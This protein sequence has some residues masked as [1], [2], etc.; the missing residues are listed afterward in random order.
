MFILANFIFTSF[1]NIENILIKVKGEYM[2]INR[3]DSTSFGAIHIQTSKMNNWQKLVSE[4]MYHTIKYSDKY[5]EM[6]KGSVDVDIYM[7]PVNK[8]D[9]ELRLVDTLSENFIKSRRGNIYKFIADG[10]YEYEHVAN[11]VLKAYEM[12]LNGTIKRPKENVSDFVNGNTD[13]CRIYP[14][15]HDDVDIKEIPRFI[16]DGMTKAEA[17]QQAYD[18]HKWTI[19]DYNS[20]DTEF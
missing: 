4:K 8:D 5:A 2:N 13:V 14:K 18:Q 7:F 11:K 12:V 19:G 1:I 9:V 20:T 6:T 17:E 15:Q 10:Y 16:K 3:V